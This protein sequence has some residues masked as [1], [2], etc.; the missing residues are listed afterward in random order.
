MD[1]FVPCRLNLPSDV[2]IEKLYE[3]VST[4]PDRFEVTRIAGMIVLA[5]IKQNGGLKPDD[6]ADGNMQAEGLSV[7]LRSISNDID[8]NGIDNKLHAKMLYISDEIYELWF[9]RP[10]NA[11]G[12]KRCF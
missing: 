1:G 11:Q 7:L 3:N 12:G 5:G 8:T 2:V 9:A 4:L 6:T 10:D